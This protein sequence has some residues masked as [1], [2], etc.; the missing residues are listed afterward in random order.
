MNIDTG[1]I[2]GAFVIS[3]QGMVRPDDNTLFETTLR[4]VRFPGSRGVILDVS[5][6]EY[7]NSRAI[8]ALMALW[9]ELSGGGTKMFIVHPGPLVERLLRSVG[10]Y[11]LVPTVKTVDEALKQ[12]QQK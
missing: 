8:G 10:I 5:R 11:T 2:D 3:V 12:M 1:E 7:L 6:L 4:D 9:I